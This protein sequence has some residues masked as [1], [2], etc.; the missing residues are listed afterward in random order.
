MNTVW[1]Y[2]LTGGANTFHIPFD[3]LA[4]RFVVISAIAGNN[5]EVLSMGSDYRFITE[6]EVVLI[7]ELP[8]EFTMIEVRRV[9]DAKR[10]VDFQDGSILRATD[11]N[12]SQL[13]AI[14]I[15][16]EGR[17]QTLDLCRQYADAAE[18]DADRAAELLK[19]IQELVTNSGWDSTLRQ[20]LG[21]EDGYKM[22]PSVAPKSYV[23]RIPITAMDSYDNSAIE[24]AIFESVMKYGYAY[25][26]GNGS[27]YTKYRISNTV[28]PPF[29]ISGS[30]VIVD[31]M[32]WIDSNY[33]HY[34]F[35][36]TLKFEGRCKFTFR[37]ELFGMTGGEVDALPN[38]ARL[39]PNPINVVPIDF[40]DVTMYTMLEDLDTFAQ[41][42]KGET[43]DIA[44][45]FTSEAGKYCGLFTDI[46][47]GETISAHVGARHGATPP[48]SSGVML[49]G[50][51]G[52]ILF[53][54]FSNGTEWR[55]RVKVKGKPMQWGE[56][57]QV[58]EGGLLKSYSASN[59]T[60]G[61]SLLSTDTFHF[62]VNGVSLTPAFG[63]MV[64]NIYEIGF[65]TSSLTTEISRVT[66]LNCYTSKGGVFG[67]SPLNILVRGDSTAE[68]FISTFDKYLPQLLDGTMGTRTVHIENKA[69][70]G[71]FMRTQLD[72][73]KTKGAGDAY[74]VIMV[75]GTNEG[76]GNTD[77]KAFAAMVKE[78][79]D[80][81]IANGRIPLWVEPWMWYSKE[82]VDGA[83]QNSNNY[84]NVA[85]LRE[86]GKRVM[87]AYGDKAILVPTTHTL[88]APFPHYT[89]M[90]VPPLLRDDIHQD[91]LGYK[92]YAEAIASA[93]AAWTSRT[94][95]APRPASVGWSR[96]HATVEWPSS[97]TNHS[98][99]ISMTV[100]SFNNGE[101]VMRLPR[102]MRP[103]IPINVPA[104]FSSDNMMYAT[105]IVTIFTNG[106]VVLNGLTTQN[107]KVYFNVTW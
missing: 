61:V 85:A 24:G 105:G 42:A 96:N 84:Q 21:A 47:V 1:T 102:G 77:P 81:C 33:D 17:E 104:T 60:V 70:A 73:L 48:E 79:A 75:G 83:G 92:L 9:T 46:N 32:V 31:K 51:N 67:H 27:E 95:G 44:C 106:E 80:W 11:L 25:I 91:E 55:Y 20:E 39:N 26:P 71:A 29:D 100:S 19:R 98:A 54:G 52:W 2:P 38:I 87:A 72:E 40:E 82:F 12:V 69:V 86:A 101:V 49:R 14:H 90:G 74:I 59:A 58:P 4:R 35:Y 65:V 78:F 15:A 93:I 107:G 7:R 37:D 8:S 41:G 68:G 36:K 63:S 53:D 16:E 10:V 99:S 62:V 23:T 89:K 56:P 97:V 22:L 28:T 3:Y 88:P 103:S 66:G 30:R 94:V 6:R 5:R 76:Q 64:G 45:E 34:S 18:E 57:I 43:S 13:Q 50:D